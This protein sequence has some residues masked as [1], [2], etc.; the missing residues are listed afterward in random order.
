MQLYVSDLTLRI[1]GTLRPADL[2]HLLSDVPFGSQ[3]GGNKDS[4]PHWVASLKRFIIIFQLPCG[5]EQGQYGPIY[6]LFPIYSSWTERNYKNKFSC[7][8]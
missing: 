6:F 2:H 4:M 3:W 7:T 5:W 8:I 1:R